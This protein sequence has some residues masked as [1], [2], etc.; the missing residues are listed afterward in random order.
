MQHEANIRIA[1]PAEP[2]RYR[3]FIDGA[4][5]DAAG[6]G[7]RRARRRR[8]DRERGLANLY[9]MALVRPGCRFA[10][11]DLTCDEARSS[12]V[13]HEVVLKE[14]VMKCSVAA[15]RDDMDEARTL[16]AARK[17]SMTRPRASLAIQRF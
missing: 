3:I 2:L 13:P 17:T 8:G 12:F 11:F 6:G 4:R 1:I 9:E 5:T 15:M 10:G 7:Y 14:I 16:L